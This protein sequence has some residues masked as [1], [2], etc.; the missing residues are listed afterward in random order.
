MHRPRQPGQTR[1]DAKIGRCGG[2]LFGVSLINAI[3]E[4]LLLVT[5]ECVL[6]PP[7]TGVQNS[8]KADSYTSSSKFPIDAILNT[9]HFELAV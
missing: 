9:A 3:A 8:G 6:I 4:R 7:E 1:Y 2:A 5:L